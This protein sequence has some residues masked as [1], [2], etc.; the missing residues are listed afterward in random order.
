MS[1]MWSKLVAPT[2]MLGR[3]KFSV[4]PAPP[5]TFMAPGDAMRAG[6]PGEKEVLSLDPPR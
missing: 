1:Q 6:R 5:I 3:S 2:G 4:M